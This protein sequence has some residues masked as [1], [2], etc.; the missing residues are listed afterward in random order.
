MANWKP[1]VLGLLLV[2]IFT[3]GWVVRGW[4]EGAQ[5]TARLEAQEEG[6]RQ[7]AELAGRVSA[8]T[9][10]AIQGIQI[11]NKTI[12]QKATKEV[13]HDTVYSECVLTADG[14]LMANKARRAAGKPDTPL[15]GGSPAPG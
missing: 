13:F 8:Q 5:D 10:I 6:R 7:L 4:Y 11:E 2:M 15:P 12:Y 14:L 1:Y 9:E 3:S